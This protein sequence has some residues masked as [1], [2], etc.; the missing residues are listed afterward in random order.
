MV[1]VIGPELESRP[2]LIFII[3]TFGR[4]EDHLTIG[5]RDRGAPN[6]PVDVEKQAQSR[7]GNAS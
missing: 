7:R 4:S 3:Y 2:R 6:T 1:S 5:V